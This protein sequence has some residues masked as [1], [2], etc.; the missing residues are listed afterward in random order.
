MINFKNQI[1]KILNSDLVLETKIGG[2]SYY[3][4]ASDEDFI[5]AL[6]L[7]NKLAVNT[8]FYEMDDFYNSPNCFTLSDYAIVNDNGVL[9]CNFEVK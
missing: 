1:K 6:D 3:L 9:K 5:V 7:K 4:P 8:G 2:I